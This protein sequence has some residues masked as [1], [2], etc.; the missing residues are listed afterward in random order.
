MKMKSEKFPSD[1]C[2]SQNLKASR[3]DERKWKNKKTRH[4]FITQF[5][6]QLDTLFYVAMFSEAFSEVRQEKA[7]RNI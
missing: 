5:Y 7:F 2:E 3:E 4:N 6:F 1:V